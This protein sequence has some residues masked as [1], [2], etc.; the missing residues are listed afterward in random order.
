M[1]VCV[2][3]CVC[4]SLWNGL[5]LI[6]CPLKEGQKIFLFYIVS[7]DLLGGPSN[8]FFNGY[9]SSFMGVKR[10]TYEF[11]YSPLSSAKVKNEWSYTS[12]PPSPY[13]VMVWMGTWLPLICIGTSWQICYVCIKSQKL[14]E[15]GESNVNPKTAK[16]CR[17]S[18]SSAWV[19]NVLCTEGL[20]LY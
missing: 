16:S 9:C 2:C 7:I 14:H 17:P 6:T 15:K 8:R 4:V 3:V 1:C 10:P 5:F 20:G 19:G 13:A 12:T 18:G 11:D